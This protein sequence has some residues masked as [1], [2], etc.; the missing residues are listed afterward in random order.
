M[1]EGNRPVGRPPRE[2]R[3]EKVR[4]K[5]ERPKQWTPPELLPHIDEKDGYSYRY[6]RTATMGQADP[7]NVSAKFREG[8][9]PVKASEHPEAF[10]MTD[11][12]SQFS[13]AIE[14]G[15]LLL[16][17][18]DEELTQQRDAYVDNRTSQATQS[19]DSNYMRENDPRMPLFKD[20]STKVTFGSGGGQGNA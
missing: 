6:I 4:A 20:K 8:W 17:K 16:C 3:E 10:S 15:G 2:N 13:D 18:T 5:E 11:P 14:V 19:V 12:N 1:A 7:K 9:E